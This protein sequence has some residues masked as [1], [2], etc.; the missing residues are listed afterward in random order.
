MQY[1]I[2]C[3]TLSIEP[4]PC[5]FKFARIFSPETLRSDGYIECIS[6]K[7]LVL[8]QVDLYAEFNPTRLLPFLVASQSYPLEA[9]LEVCR[10]AGLVREQVMWHGG[11]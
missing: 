9:A 8:V 5:A 4:Y 1:N 11:I 7:P 10:V 2:I 6:V 3:P